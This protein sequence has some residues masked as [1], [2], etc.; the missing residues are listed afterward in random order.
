MRTKVFEQEESVE[1][2]DSNRERYLVGALC[3]P[4][5]SPEKKVCHQLTGGY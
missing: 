5:F 1:M 3:C 4:Y 2:P